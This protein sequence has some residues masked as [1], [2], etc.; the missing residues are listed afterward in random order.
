[1]GRNG[2]IRLNAEEMV[3]LMLLHWSGSF[4]LGKGLEIILPYGV[5]N[6]MRWITRIGLKIAKKDFKRK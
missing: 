1:M 6:A 2:E 3:A 5:K 4:P